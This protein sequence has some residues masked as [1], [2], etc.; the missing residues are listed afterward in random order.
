MRG[1]KLLDG[2]KL[3]KGINIL[4]LHLLQE[5]NS[6][7]IHTI[8]HEEIQ[9]AGFNYALLGGNHIAEFLPPEKPLILYPGS[10]EPLSPS[11]ENDLHK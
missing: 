4:L 2:L 8:S 7:E 9:K 11:E 10:P 1:Y 3:E 5:S 6:S